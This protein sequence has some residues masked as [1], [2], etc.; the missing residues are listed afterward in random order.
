MELN[1]SLLIYDSY[2]IE[3]LPVISDELGIEFM[4]SVFY[5]EAVTFLESLGV[6]RYK[7]A[8]R[9]NTNCFFNIIC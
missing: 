6:K 7:V 5:P 1:N 4:C 8:S 3:F 2:F 9:T